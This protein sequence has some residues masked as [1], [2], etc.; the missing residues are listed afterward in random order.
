MPNQ[1]ERLLSDRLSDLSMLQEPIPHWARRRAK[2]NGLEEMQQLL[3]KDGRMHG[4]AAVVDIRF[5][6]VDKAQESCLVTVVTD[7]GSIINAMSISELKSGFHIG[8]WI[9]REFQTTEATE[10]VKRWIA[11]VYHRSEN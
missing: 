1:Y 6:D 10:A 8:E 7:V 5:T 4:N 9:M 2:P 3:T 11:E